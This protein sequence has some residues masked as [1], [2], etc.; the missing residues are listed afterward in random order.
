MFE[1][2][3]R[4]PYED[5]KISTDLSEF[6]TKLNNV[7][8]AQLFQMLKDLQ[9]K[10]NDLI[11]CYNNINVNS[12]GNIRDSVRDIKVGCMKALDELK[13]KL[14]I[15]DIVNNPNIFKEFDIAYKELAKI[16]NEKFQQ[17]LNVFRELNQKVSITVTSLIEKI[18]NTILESLKKCLNDEQ[19]NIIKSKI[20]EKFVA[21]VDKNSIIN[22]TL[23]GEKSRLSSA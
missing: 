18:Y 22:C 11:D 7:I 8:F 5:F 23:S 16:Q 13:E 10:C 14:N 15:K 2:W 17:N 12:V 21:P 20:N 4:N 1:S 3:T 9:N 19:F 6:K